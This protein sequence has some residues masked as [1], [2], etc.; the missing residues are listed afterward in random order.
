VVFSTAKSGTRWGD[1]DMFCYQGK[2]LVIWAGLRK[3][4]GELSGGEMKTSC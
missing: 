3:N 2:K 4:A 1:G